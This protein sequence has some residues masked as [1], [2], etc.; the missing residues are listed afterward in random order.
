[1]GG[2]GCGSGCGQ[3]WLVVVGVGSGLGF[4]VGLREERYI[5]KERRRDEFR[6]KKN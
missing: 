6:I 2:G 5:E 1:M 4:A 3:W